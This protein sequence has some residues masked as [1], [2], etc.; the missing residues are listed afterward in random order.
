MKHN[1]MKTRLATL[2]KIAPG[3]HRVVSVYLN[4]RWSD[5]QQR[6][7]VRIFLKNELRRARE[8][9]YPGPFLEAD[10]ELARIRD[11]I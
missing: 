2:A 10:P 3:R 5:E 1:D 4:T 6:E 9:G 8:L 11:R 7:R